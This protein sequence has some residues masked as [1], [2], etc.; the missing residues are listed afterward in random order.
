MLAPWVYIQVRD[1]LSIDPFRLASLAYPLPV[2]AVWLLRPG[3]RQLRLLGYLVGVVAVISVVLGLV[4]PSHAIFRDAAGAVI[5]EDKNLLP[6]GML[7]GIYTHGNSLGQFLALG[8]P[9]V[10]LIRR[11]SVRRRPAG[12]LHVRPDLERGA[13]LDLLGRRP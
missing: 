13:I 6:W 9:M 8:I 7:I 4:L 5:T 2:V 3:L 1:W 10:T 12:D 11:T